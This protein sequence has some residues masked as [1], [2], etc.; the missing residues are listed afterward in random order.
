MKSLHNLII[1]GWHVSVWPL[2]VLFGKEFVPPLWKG[3]LIHV[4]AVTKH[5]L[6]STFTIDELRIFVLFLTSRHPACGVLFHGELSDSREWNGGLNLGIAPLCCRRC[7]P[8][9][10]LCQLSR[11]WCAQSWL[12]GIAFRLLARGCPQERGIGRMSHLNALKGARQ[13]GRRASFLLIWIWFPIALTCRVAWWHWLTSVQRP[14]SW[15][16]SRWEDVAVLNCGEYNP[17]SWVLPIFTSE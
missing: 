12:V 1:S 8:S 10:V 11:G 14:V 15:I 6:K 7:A 4:W 13:G 2:V 3:S 17:F 16:Q 9:R 5:L